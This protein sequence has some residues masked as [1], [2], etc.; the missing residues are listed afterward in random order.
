MKIYLKNGRAVKTFNKKE[1]ESEP[2]MKAQ[3]PSKIEAVPTV[4]Q[5]R[6]SLEIKKKPLKL[7]I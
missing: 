1:K 2:E 6:L 4:N 7:S 5:Q 3:E